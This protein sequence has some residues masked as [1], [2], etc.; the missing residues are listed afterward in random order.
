MALK[1]TIQIENFIPLADDGSIAVKFK[2]L[3][4]G[5]VYSNFKLERMEEEAQ[6]AI[7]N[8]TWLFKFCL[9]IRLIGECCYVY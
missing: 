9:V 5:F 8:E 1:C 4:G 2:G 6:E 7:N 3:N